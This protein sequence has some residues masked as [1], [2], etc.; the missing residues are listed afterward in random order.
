M[1]NV[2]LESTAVLPQLLLRHLEEKNCLAI[3]RPLVAQF[4]GDKITDDHNLQDPM[5]SV[6]DQY[7]LEY[8]AWR[9]S[10]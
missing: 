6:R 3:R 4:N 5:E 9:L 8:S 1:W 7:I 10:N 2:E